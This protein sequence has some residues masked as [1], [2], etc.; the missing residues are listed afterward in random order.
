MLPE[1]AMMVVGPEGVGKSTL[2]ATMYKEF[3]NTEQTSSAFKFATSKQA[4]VALE[5]SYQKL[6]EVVNQPLFTQVNRRFLPSTVKLTPY[7]FEISFKGKQELLF[8]C[9]DCPGDLVWADVEEDEMFAD[10]KKKL[11]QSTVIVNVI[12]GAA[13]VEGSRAFAEK[14]NLPHRIYELLHPVLTN[15]RSHLVLF[16]VTKC[17]TWLKGPASHRQKLLN[18][19]EKRYHSLLTLIK[20]SPSVVGVFMPVKTL[21][22]VEF[23]H[24]EGRGETERLVFVRKAN[25]AF[26]PKGTA[27]PLFYA[28]TFALSQYDRKRGVWFNMLRRFSPE[29]AGSSLALS[30]SPPR[31][32]KSGLWKKL[33]R[34]LARE[35]IVFRTALNNFAQSREK[36]GKVYGNESLLEVVKL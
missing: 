8:K 13:L 30:K 17:E 28:L 34:R 32:N 15:N 5:E 25:L 14:V 9:Y 11:G 23:S 10:F 24:I 19:F 4:T 33:L 6:S 29:G 35:E 21:G 2:L 27:Q 36:G 12:D 22:C 7:Q 16:V 3:I 26:A 20:E 31:N 1:M 18:A